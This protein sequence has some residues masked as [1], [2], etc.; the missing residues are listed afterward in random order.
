MI[1]LLF[2]CKHKLSTGRIVGIEA[3]CYTAD[4]FTAFV[5]KIN[6]MQLKHDYMLSAHI[7][8]MGF[9]RENVGEEKAQ[10]RSGYITKKTARWRL[11]K[12]TF[13]V[14]QEQLTLKTVLKL[15]SSQVSRGLASVCDLVVERLTDKQIAS[16]ISA[17][18]LKQYWDMLKDISGLMEPDASESR[19]AED[20]RNALLAKIH[21]SSSR[22]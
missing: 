8:V 15:R 1:K 18:D 20:V 6:W 7:S 3:F 12:E 11:E 14:E 5:D 19:S 21:V 13:L 9:L 4:A 2:S 16:T 22:H 10:K 17:K